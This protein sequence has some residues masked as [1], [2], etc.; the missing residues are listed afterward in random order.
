M[1]RMRTIALLACAGAR[2]AVAAGR[3]TDAKTF[4]VSWHLL[5]CTQKGEFDVKF[6]IR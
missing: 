6:N 5:D 4:R 1:R 3:W 2:T